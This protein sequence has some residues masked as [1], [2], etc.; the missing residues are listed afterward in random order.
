VQ[1][2]RREV[3]HPL[4]QDD[5]I[6]ASTCLPRLPNVLG[7]HNLTYAASKSRRFVGLLLC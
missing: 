7:S 6:Q 4:V 2:L 5:D 1:G 3:P